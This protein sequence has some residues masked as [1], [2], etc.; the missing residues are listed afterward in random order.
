MNNNV[1][2]SYSWFLKSFWDEWSLSRMTNSYIYHV[3][4]GVT[5][6][7]SDLVFLSTSTLL[8]PFASG[9]KIKW[10][11][12]KWILAYWWKYDQEF[13]IFVRYGQIIRI[14]GCMTIEWDSK[15]KSLWFVNPEF[16]L[17]FLILN[18]KNS[19]SCTTKED[20]LVSLIGIKC[21]SPTIWATKP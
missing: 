12:S 8:C 17:Y 10:W 9:I 13:V 3:Y 11:N 7:S 14:Y 20:R 15:F 5:M 21:S 16:L 19:K 6:Q 2:Y 1:V 18:L 4:V